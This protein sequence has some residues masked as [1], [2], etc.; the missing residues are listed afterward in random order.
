MSENLTNLCLPLG[1]GGILGLSIMGLFCDIN[2][3]LLL[4]VAIIV[5]IGYF[6]HQRFLHVVKKEL[7]EI[8]KLIKAKGLSV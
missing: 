4:T 1:A 3:W 6:A 5:N 8:Q 2:S 7:I